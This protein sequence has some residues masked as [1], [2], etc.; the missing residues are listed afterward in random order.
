M[1]TFVYTC[2]R[3]IHAYVTYIQVAKG[4]IHYAPACI[5][6]LVAPCPAVKLHAIIQVCMHA[7]MY[8]LMHPGCM[9]TSGYR[10]D[11]CIYIY[12]TCV[13]MYGF[14]CT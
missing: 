6:I 11:A 13:C 12:I 2:I 10:I 5:D 14:A 8:A 9:L 1:H 4:D 3:N 7:I